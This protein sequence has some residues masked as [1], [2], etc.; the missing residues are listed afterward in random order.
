M[1]AYVDP[2]DLPK[3]KRMFA[4]LTGREPWPDRRTVA[5]RMDVLFL[6]RLSRWR[7]IRLPPRIDGGICYHRD[8]RFSAAEIKEQLEQVF[9]DR[10]LQVSP[11][12]SRYFELRK[13]SPDA[14]SEGRLTKL[15]ENASFGAS[16]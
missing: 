10:G 1:T 4:E 15:K 11:R 9:Q 3:A 16:Q 13:L 7:M 14:R 5:E 12:G 8:G 6:G 2:N